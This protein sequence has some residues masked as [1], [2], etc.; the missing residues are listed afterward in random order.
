MKG[1]GS[2]ASLRNA[3]TFATIQNAR[4]PMKDRMNVHEPPN[5][6]TPSARRWPN[7]RCSWNARCGS[8]EMV[9]R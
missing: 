3:H 1:N 8:R 6:A 4:N 9:S 2:N 7:V 5:A